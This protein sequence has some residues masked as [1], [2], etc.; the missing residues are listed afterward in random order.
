VR[1]RRKDADW[2]PRGRYIDELLADPARVKARR[3]QREADFWD[4]VADRIRVRIG[5]LPGDFGETPASSRPDLR[6]D[7]RYLYRAL[8]EAESRSDLAAAKAEAYRRV[9]AAEEQCEISSYVASHARRPN[10]QP[11]LER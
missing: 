10:R 8:A 4:I 9:H 3:F 6:A 11:R 7:G 5:E 2:D 1:R